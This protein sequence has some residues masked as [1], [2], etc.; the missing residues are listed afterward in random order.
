MGLLGLAPAQCTQNLS[1]DPMDPACDT[2][3]ALTLFS[4]LG[5]QGVQWPH[6]GLNQCYDGAASSTCPVSGF[7]RQDADYFRARTFTP[8]G[9]GSMV[10]DEGTGLVWQRCVVGHSWDG[11]TC[12]GSPQSLTHTAAISACQTLSTNIGGQWRLPTFRELST[13]YVYDG[14]SPAADVSAFPGLPAVTGLWS[15]TIY[16]G[17]PTNGLATNLGTGVVINYSLS[18][19]R[20]V[21]CVAGPN[22][23]NADFRVVQAGVVQDLTTGDYWTACPVLGGGGLDT[24]TGCAGPAGLENWSTALQSCSNLDGTAGISGWRLPSL[25]EMMA[26]PDYSSVSGSMMNDTYFPNGPASA[27][28]AT[29]AVY[30]SLDT[31]FVLQLG[32]T[33]TLTQNPLKTTNLNHYCIASTP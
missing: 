29:T 14:S 23:N 11:A 10:R 18:L 31:A 30:N 27:W 3:A 33:A 20:Y 21:L 26:I 32:A 22:Y 1:C 8:L 12:S 13:F 16:Q 7:P 28:T 17:N 6:S 4:A 9:N 15:S 19:S 24:S 25:R 5:S 2:D